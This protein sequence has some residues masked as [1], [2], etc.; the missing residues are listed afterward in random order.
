LLNENPEESNEHLMEAPK[1]SEKQSSSRIETSTAKKPNNR[2]AVK[3]LEQA[4]TEGGKHEKIEI[5]PKTTGKPGEDF[6]T[7]A[8]KVALNSK[9]ATKP[10]INGELTT[11]STSVMK[12]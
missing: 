8:K 6:K 7:A 11:P 9:T 10:N 12:K 3:I 2:S 5:T 4:E 1:I